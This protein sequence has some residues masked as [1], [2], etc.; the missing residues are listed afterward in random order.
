MI[1]NARPLRFARARM[2]IER[3]PQRGTRPVVTLASPL[4]RFGTSRLPP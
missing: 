1:V 4:A 2:S 3:E